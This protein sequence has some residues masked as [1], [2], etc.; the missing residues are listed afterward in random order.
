LIASSGE[1]RGDDRERRR[2][3]PTSVCQ[4]P[5][6]TARRL[7]PAWLT[8]RP[9]RRYAQL[10]RTGRLPSAG[11][12][13]STWL[14]RS[15]ARFSRTSFARRKRTTGASQRR[16]VMPARELPVRPDLDQLK[17]Q[18]KDLLRA[19]HDGEP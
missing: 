13:E 8:Q 5:V 16:L 1:T 11:R 4:R 2:R 10:R 18:A 7:G 17:H 15:I 14:L 3:I 19:L 12:T 6:P 9:T